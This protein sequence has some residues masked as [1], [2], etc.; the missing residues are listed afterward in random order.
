MASILVLTKSGEGI[1]LANRLKREGNIVKVSILENPYVE[2]KDKEVQLIKDPLQMI[3]QFDLVICTSSSLGI[4]AEQ[5]KEKGIQTLGGVFNDKLENDIE[6]SNN[7][8]DVIY[9]NILTPTN[10]GIPISL[11]GWFNKESFS[12]YYITFQYDKFLEHNRGAYINS[13]SVVKS[14]LSCKLTNE[15]LN[16][17]IGLLTKVNYLGPL[18]LNVLLFEDG[19][20]ILNFLTSIDNTFYTYIELLKCSIW[21][22][23][24]KV[25]NKQEIL[26]REDFALSINLSIPPYPYLS[27]DN[28]D[29]S[30][31][32]TIPQPAINHL[33][34]FK[35]TAGFLG[36]I[37]SRGDTINE[38]RRRVYR[39]AKYIITSDFVQYRSDIGYGVEEKVNKLK[40][41]KWLD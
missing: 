8:L 39:T 26:I 28:I 20:I 12:N 5:C 3:E 18:T 35:D 24:Q 10:K 17:I 33:Y 4:T 19:K 41:W 7:V 22:F 36:Y 37:T 25:V 11:T 34:L 15:C 38:A 6:Y 2:L 31:F 9:K 27:L 29:I 21:N 16:P 13:G 14:I 23:L 40:E 32:L 1:P 30:K